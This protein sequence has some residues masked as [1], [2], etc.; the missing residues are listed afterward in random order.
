MRGGRYQRCAEEE[1]ERG[2][3]LRGS[4][5]VWR[6]YSVTNLEVVVEIVKGTK[7]ARWY[8]SSAARGRYVLAQRYSLDYVAN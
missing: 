6:L 1:V 3:S 2:Y 7:V 5:A 8:G 4:D